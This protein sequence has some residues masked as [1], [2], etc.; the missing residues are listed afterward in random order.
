MKYDS[1][2]PFTPE[3]ATIIAKAM[4]D[5]VMRE[6]AR[7]MAKVMAEALVKGEAPDYTCVHEVGEMVG[8]SEGIECAIKIFTDEAK[9]RETIAFLNKE[10][11]PSN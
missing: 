4:A 9:F 7:N 2:M 10:D 11:T 5:G 8:Q 6:S 3:N 1:N